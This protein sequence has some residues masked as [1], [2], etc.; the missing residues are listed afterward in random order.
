M[1]ARAM[2]RQECV[3][4]LLHNLPKVSV[5]NLVRIKEGT[6][7]TNMSAASFVFIHKNTR[8]CFLNTRVASSIRHLMFVC[9]GVDGG[10]L[11]SLVFLFGE[12][13]KNITKNVGEAER[14]FTR[15]EKKIKHRHCEYTPLLKLQTPPMHWTNSCST[16]HA[17]N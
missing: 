14:K 3:H 11:L 6:T 1:V 15:L 10:L 8:S 12:V 9:T 7:I 16:D 2:L 13:G 17:K 4:Q 5:D